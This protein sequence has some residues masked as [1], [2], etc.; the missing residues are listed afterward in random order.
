MR[1]I[2]PTLNES[3]AAVSRFFAAVSEDCSS[4]W[5]WPDLG[6]G[7]AGEGVRHRQVSDFQNFPTRRTPFP[8]FP[9]YLLKG[10]QYSTPPRPEIPRYAPGWWPSLDYVHWAGT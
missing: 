2:E 8:L 1:E 10:P 6:G 7:D 3:L 9:K 5:Q 4:W